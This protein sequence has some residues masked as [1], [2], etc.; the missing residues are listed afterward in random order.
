MRKPIDMIAT[1]T[2][3]SSRYRRLQTF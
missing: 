1:T 3:Q 2:V